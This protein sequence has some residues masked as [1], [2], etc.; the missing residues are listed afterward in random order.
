M[1]IASKITPIMPEPF[2][3][4]FIT[5][6]TLKTKPKMHIIIVGGRAK[7]KFW[8]GLDKNMSIMM[9]DPNA[10]PDNNKPRSPSVSTPSLKIFTTI[11]LPMVSYVYPSFTLMGRTSTRGAVPCSNSLKMT[12]KTGIPI[13][14]VTTF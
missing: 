13:F 14:N 5:P 10:M 3:L 12:S 6:A 11:K 8:R 4:F 1:P 2:S 7:P 9:T